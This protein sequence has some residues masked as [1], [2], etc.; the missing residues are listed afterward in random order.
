MR[1]L[2]ILARPNVAT[3]IVPRHMR[4]LEITVNAKQ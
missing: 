2:E 1:G 3:C 4:G